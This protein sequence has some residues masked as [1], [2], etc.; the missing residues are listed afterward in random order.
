VIYSFLYPNSPRIIMQIIIIFF[1]NTVR[2]LSTNNE[3]P[4]T[5]A[6]YRVL[7]LSVIKAVT[8]IALLRVCI[9]FHIS[10]VKIWKM[11]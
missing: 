3:I 4:L 8:L 5:K 1:V 11:V 7:P 2:K 10:R 6:K 9:T